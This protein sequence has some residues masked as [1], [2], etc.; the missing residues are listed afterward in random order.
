MNQD[1]MNVN[2]TQVNELDDTSF[3][4]RLK[5][6]FTGGHQQ[7]QEPEEINPFAEP[8]QQAPQQMQQQVQQTSQV[9]HTQQEQGNASNTA[10]QQYVNGLNFLDGIEVN[11]EELLSNPEQLKGL[12]GN[13]ARQAYSRAMTDSATIMDKVLEQR[14]NSFSNQMAEQMKTTANGAV[15]MERVAKE[16]P[17]MKDPSAAPI[18]GQVMTGFLKQGKNPDEALQMTKDFLHKFSDK[19]VAKDAGAKAHRNDLDNLFSGLI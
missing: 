12:I 4:A 5:A 11:T 19:V 17:L 10:F 15:Q 2:Q 9:N 16:L 8:K 13:V 1:E 14:F 18:I 3:L 6:A 7:V